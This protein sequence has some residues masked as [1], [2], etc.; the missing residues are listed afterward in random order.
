[1]P[2]VNSTL[3]LSSPKFLIGPNT[4]VSFHQG[5]KEKFFSFKKMVKLLEHHSKAF[6]ES[7]NKESRRQ[8]DEECCDPIVYDE[9][10]RSS[11][12]G[13]KFDEELPNLF[14]FVESFLY[15]DNEK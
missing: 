4:S 9:P 5:T 14:S 15:F 2:G 8:F 7:N 12:L 6:I 10:Q 1:M 3:R 13:E 11:T